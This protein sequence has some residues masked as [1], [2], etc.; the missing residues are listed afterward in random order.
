MR[1]EAWKIQDFNGVWT[2]DLAIP[3]RGSTNWAMKP[4]VLGAGHLWARNESTMK[5][6]EMD[7]IW[8][9]PPINVLLITQSFYHTQSRADFIFFKLVIFPIF[10]IEMPLKI[11]SVCSE[12]PISL[13]AKDQKQ[14]IVMELLSHSHNEKATI[15]QSEE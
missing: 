3:V 12:K 6:H 11:Y 15:D 2:R 1:K 14:E 7:H 9:G 4:L 13:V 10:F 5:W 8:T